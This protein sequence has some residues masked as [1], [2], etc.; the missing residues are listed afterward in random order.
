M[1]SLRPVFPLVLQ[2]TYYA[3]GFFNVKR[4]Y[5]RYVGAEGDVELLLHPPGQVVVARINRS[6]NRNGTARVIGGALLRDW[7]REHHV[8]GAVVPVRF[9]STLRMTIG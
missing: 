9:E 3:Q 7:F 2:R 1:S 6:A 8:E 4:D 5:D